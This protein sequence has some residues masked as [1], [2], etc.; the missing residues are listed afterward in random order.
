MW[1]YL[2]KNIDDADKLRKKDTQNILTLTSNSNPYI[3]W[4]QY[5]GIRITH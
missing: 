1:T 5:V 4:S 3:L 2:D